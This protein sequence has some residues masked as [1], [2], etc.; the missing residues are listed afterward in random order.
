[1]NDQDLKK[2][3]KAV[4]DSLKPLH[5]E[6]AK[7]KKEVGS[8]R[9]IQFINSSE[10]NK[11]GQDVARIDST[12]DDIKETLDGHTKTLE[13]HTRILGQHTKMLSEHTKTLAKQG[14]KLNDVWDHAGTLTEDLTRVQI[15]FESLTKILNQHTD[16]LNRIEANAE[17]NSDDVS[18]LD[19]RV[20]TLE[21]QSGI[22]PP[23][24]LTAVK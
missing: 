11:I 12:L 22:V 4:T 8:L 2:F 18:K 23:P 16:S 21:D 6:M 9:S 24:E 15:K 13:T 10:T 1:M 7:I 20:T 14:K 3:T 19:K 5:G 17:R